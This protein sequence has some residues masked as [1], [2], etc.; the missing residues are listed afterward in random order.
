MSGT[1]LEQIRGGFEALE[2]YE[3]A[4]MAE[5][6]RKTRYLTSF[7]IYVC[8][9]HMYVYDTYFN[10]TVKSLLYVSVHLF[11]SVLRSIRWNN[12]T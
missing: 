2:V 3:K 7:I 1:I 6:D 12:N 10:D 11:Y 4:I 5:F 9:Y 8:L